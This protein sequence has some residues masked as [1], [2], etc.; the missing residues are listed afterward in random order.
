[1]GKT[2]FYLKC[3]VFLIAVCYTPAGNAAGM[4]P[5]ANFWNIGWEGWQDFFASGVNWTSTTNPW[6]PAF[7]SELQ[8]AK[9]KC[10]R[11]MD[12]NCVN[13]SCVVNWSQRIP[14][15]ANHYNSANTIPC[16]TDNYVS[17]TNTHNLV[18]NGSTSYGVAIEWQ[19]DLCNRVGADIWINVP[20]TANAAYINQLA[21]LLKN[22]LNSDLKVY[23]E[24]AN[25]LW[26]WGCANTVY[27]RNQADSLGLSGLDVG[28]YCDPWRKFDVYA[29]VR[30]FEQFESVFGANSPRI[31]K[32]IAGQVGYHWPGY[33][34]NHMVKGDL[35]CLKNATINPNH[36]TINAYAMAP[37]MGGQTIVAQKTV[38]DTCA[39]M[40]TWARNS[41]DST[42]IKLTCYEGGA[43]NYPDN[44]LTLTRDAQQEQLYADYLTALAPLVD[45]PFNQYCFY[46]G[47]WGL[48]KN[49]GDQASVSPKWRGWLNYWANYSTGVQNKT[50]S[51][52]GNQLQEHPVRVTGKGIIV[53]HFPEKDAITLVRVIALNGG[54]LLSAT[55]GTDRE[56]KIDGLKQ[57][58][59]IVEVISKN[60]PYTTKI[61]V[62]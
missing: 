1:M 56:I 52:S 39:Q 38:I 12:W 41:F 21:I 36:T 25:E 18:W 45:G 57:G 62:R 17:S 7:I 60:K 47:C 33:N 2:K 20:V 55:P 35:A 8:S 4:S 27:A 49:A 42:G 30:A 9:I 44:N 31:V 43:D 48:K 34:Y 29:S 19:I 22:Q 32:V 11:F 46:G 51:A 16:F 6:N 13:P 28:A 53:V 15:T 23:V 40:M 58:A 54:N 61:M 50:S 26:N 5:G 10:L 59:Y 14:K 3:A 37:Y 24:F